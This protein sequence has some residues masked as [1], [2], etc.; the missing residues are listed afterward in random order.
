MALITLRTFVD[1]LEAISVTGLVRSYTQGPP[2]AKPATADLP[3]MFLHLP[4]IAGATKL[5]FSE[6]GGRGALQAQVIILVEPIV[7][8]LQGTNFDASV[9]MVDALETTLIAATCDIGGVLGWT[10]RVTNWEVGG[11]MYWAVVA[12]IEGGRW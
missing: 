7:Q 8:N 11:Q 6:Q 4:Q 5:V 9:D 12:D 2:S 3:A 1:G 10:I